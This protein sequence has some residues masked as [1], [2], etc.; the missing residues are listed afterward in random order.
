MDKVYFKKEYY[1][2]WWIENELTDLYSFNIVDFETKEESTLIMSWTR[3]V[4]LDDYPDAI[5]MYDVEIDDDK[6]Y[7]LVYQEKGGFLLTSKDTI[8]L[9]KLLNDKNILFTGEKLETP[10]L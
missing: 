2:N 4:D 7:F 9:D 5:R 10:D 6:Y 3:G 1:G 8:L